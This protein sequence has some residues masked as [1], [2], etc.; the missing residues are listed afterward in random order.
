ML[1]V[2]HSQFLRSMRARSLG[3]VPRPAP[4][5][6]ATSTFERAT[7]STAR[8]DR[9][10]V[11]PPVFPP[12]PAGDAD[13]ARLLGLR[14]GNTAAGP[15]DTRIRQLHDDLQ[16]LGFLP[17]GFEKNSGYGV[18]FGDL[19]RGAVEALQARHGLAVTGEVDAATVEVLREPRFPVEGRCRNIAAQHPELGRPV[20]PLM[21]TADGAQRQ[22]FDRGCVELRG[23]VA[24]VLAP[25]GSELARRTLGTFDSAEEANRVFL[26]QE[27]ETAFFDAPGTNPRPYGPN[28]CG[29]T[30]ALIALGAL[31]LVRTPTAAEAPG[32]IDRMRDAIYKTDTTTSSTMGMW[33]V[34]QGLQAYGATGTAIDL[35]VKK[36]NGAQAYENGLAKYSLDGLDAALARNHPVIIGGTPAG[37]P[38]VPAV[39]A[40]WARRLYEQVDA[41]GQRGYLDF[42]KQGN[43]GHFCAVVGKTADGNYLVADPLA[44]HGTLEATPQE[45]LA[46]FRAGWGEALEV[47]PLPPQA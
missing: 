19:T 2:R 17:A 18:R 31:G 42:N 39:G 10:G 47:Q 41:D 20:S 1:T 29:P 45:L 8:A 32:A 11:A 27:G 9:L 13:A 26:N 33:H 25:D 21:T 43:F 5:A 4:R 22:W 40:A 24:R 46:F 12:P 14:R 35:L 7:R 44:R 28:D 36:P 6:P 34:K 15:G 30:S 38:D 3:L 16:R 37:R 23:D